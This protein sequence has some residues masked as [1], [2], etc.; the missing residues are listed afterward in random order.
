MIGGLKDCFESINDVANTQCTSI[1][2][3]KA[4]EQKDL[5]ILPAKRFNLKLSQLACDAETL[6]VLVLQK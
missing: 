2:S 6:K 4:N 3:S 1:I 5:G